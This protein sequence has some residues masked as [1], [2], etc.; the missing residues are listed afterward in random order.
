MFTY[1]EKL[2]LVNEVITPKS[3]GVYIAK[4]YLLLK[5]LYL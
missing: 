1:A 3:F 2:Y 5:N 4:C